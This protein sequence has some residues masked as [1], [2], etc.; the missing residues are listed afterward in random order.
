MSSRPASNSE[1]ARSDVKTRAFRSI[2]ALTLRT[3]ASQGLRVINA[4]VLSRLLFPSDYGAFGIVAFATSL[5]A[6]LGDL[7]L[8]A[9]LV[10]QSHEPTEDE[11]TTAFWSHQALT[12]TIVALLLVLAPLVSNAYDLGPS[13]TPMVCA[14]AVGLFF[15]SLRVIPMMML[16]RHLH[17]PAVARMELVEGLTQ[18]GTT[19]ALALLGWG[20]WALALGGLVRGAVG[21]VILWSA[22][23]WRPR[24]RFRKDI[25]QRL[26]GFGIWFQLGGIIPAILSGWIPLIVGKLLGKDAVGLVN[27]AWA[28]A[29]VPLMVSGILNRVAYPA[30]SRMQEDGAGLAEYLRTSIRRISAVLCL[31]IPFGV[32]ALPM[33]IPVI[34]GER[35]RPAAPLVQWYTLEATLMAVHGL[36]CSQQNAS[37]QARERVYVTTVSSILRAGL[38]TLAVMHLGI[39]GIGIMGAAMTL[40]ELWL[41]AWMVARRSPHLTG[42]EAEVMEPFLTVGALLAFAVAVARFAT[43]AQGPLVQALVAGGALALGVV[44]RERLRRGLSLMGEV[45]SVVQYVR[46]RRAAS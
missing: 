30:Y 16:E 9:S 29:S 4:L 3:F 38:G 22:S 32:I 8:S 28:L 46:S 14:M 20:P 5:G 34:F 6:Y 37:G 11:T 7:G 1:Q 39:V 12:S 41:T 10:R 23:P 44:A 2:V 43:G 45:R 36:L 17:F 35:W 19:I 25:L 42:L 15:S 24:G 26:L 31:A 33:L 13:G 18:T 40:T 21:L 27:W